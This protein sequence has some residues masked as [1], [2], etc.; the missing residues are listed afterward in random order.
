MHTTNGEEAEEFLTAVKNS[1][2]K[3]QPLKRLEI[4]TYG[5]SETSMKTLLDWIKQNLRISKLVVKQFGLIEIVKVDPE[6]EEEE[7]H[8][9]IDYFRVD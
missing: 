8:A 7:E 6:E 9:A 5:Y 1:L 3:A 2:Q 4:C